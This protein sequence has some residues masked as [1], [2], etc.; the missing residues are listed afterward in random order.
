MKYGAILADPP[1]TFK[2]YSKKGKGRS[3]E[4]HYGCMSLRD[5][6]ELEIPAA[7]NCVLFMWTTDPMLR[8]A[9][10]LMEAW[11]FT[12]KTIAFTWAKERTG[13]DVIGYASQPKTWFTGMG[14]WTRANPEMCLLGT[15][16]KP[17]RIH[18]DVR[19]LIVAPRREHS[20]KPDEIYER[21]ERLV[22]GPYLEMFA[23]QQRNGWDSWGDETEKFA[24]AD[25]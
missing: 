25:E 13:M 23:R 14:Y 7:D 1:W 5:L 9:L 11:N 19:Q 10:E 16:G 2:T 6:W 21:I 17:K 15:R 4:Q 20:R 24:G 12:Y 22:P 18:K 3:A 8:H